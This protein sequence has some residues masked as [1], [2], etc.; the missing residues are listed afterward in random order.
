MFEKP[1]EPVSNLAI[2]GRYIL[3]SNIFSYL[4]EL[5]EG[6]GGEIQLTDAL[7]NM[8]LDGKEVYA[9]HYHGSRF[10]IGNKL[11]WLKANIELGSEDEEVGKELKGWLE[12]FMKL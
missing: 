6:Y 7:R 9:Y 1:E 5:K 4:N 12:E 8:V 11:D 2:I 3:T 10:D